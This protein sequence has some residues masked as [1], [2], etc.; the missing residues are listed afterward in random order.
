MH[1]DLR[2]D[3]QYAKTKTFKRKYQEHVF[4]YAR[5]KN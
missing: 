1:K 3:R 5:K 4:Y 2:Y